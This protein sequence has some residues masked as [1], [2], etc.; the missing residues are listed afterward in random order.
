MLVNCNGVGVEL[1]PGGDPT[2]IYSWSPSNGLTNTNSPNP[3]AN[4]TTTTVYTVTVTDGICE[5]T[6]TVEV[7]VPDEP[8]LAGFSFSF[9]D[10][11]DNA[12]IEFTDTTQIGNTT[13][14]EWQWVF[15]GNDNDTSFLQNPI[16]TFNQSDT[17]NAELTV[18]TADGCV[19]T[20]V[21]RLK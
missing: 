14:T 12:V 5:F 18:T 8:I 13:I 19:A 4:P 17:I 11:T 16:L 7:Q 21:K 9:E 3:I 15:E 10:C 20:E 6:R 2:N 1:N